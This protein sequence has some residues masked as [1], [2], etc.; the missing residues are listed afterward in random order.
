MGMQT[1]V[2]PNPFTNS[3]HIQTL[4]LPAEVKVHNVSGQLILQ[5]ILTTPNELLEMKNVP[6]G[7]YFME[8]QG[9]SL[10]E[11]YKIIKR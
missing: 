4:A 7:L 1:I 9:K 5:K 10:S 8:V 11:H 3:L 6:D 2:Y